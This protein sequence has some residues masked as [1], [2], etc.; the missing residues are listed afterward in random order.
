MDSGHA[1]STCVEAVDVAVPMRGQVIRANVD[2]EASGQTGLSLAADGAKAVV[3]LRDGIGAASVGLAVRKAACG[4][5]VVARAS[6]VAM[7][8]RRC[9]RCWPSSRCMAMS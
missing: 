4:V 7:F 3:A 6:G 1:L 5:V 9:W 2:G 8:G